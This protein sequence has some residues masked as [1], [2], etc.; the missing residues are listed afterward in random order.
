[1][2]GSS[3][4]IETTTSARASISA[5][6]FLGFRPTRSIP[7]SR[8]ASMTMGWTA[9]AGL[10]PPETAAYSG[11]ACS[12]RACAIWLRPAFRRQRKR[13]VMERLYPIAKPHRR[14]EDSA[15][16]RRGELACARVLLAWVIGG[17]EPAAL[18][19]RDARA[20]SEHRS[21]FDLGQPELPPRLHDRFK[22][23]LPQREPDVELRKRA[24]LPHEVLPAAVELGG[25]RLVPGRRAST[26]G[27]D[28]Y[29]VER[30]AVVGAQSIGP[31]REPLSKQLP[32]EPLAGAVSGEHPPRSVR[33][34]RPRREPHDEEP[35]FRIAKPGHRPPPVG[36]I[37][38]GGAAHSGHLG[39]ILA[40]SRA[41]FA[42]GHVARDSLERSGVAIRRHIWEYSR[43]VDRS[44]RVHGF[45]R[46][47]RGDLGGA[48]PPSRRGRRPESRRVDSRFPLLMEVAPQ[49]LRPRDRGRGLLDREEHREG[50]LEVSGRR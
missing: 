10:E 17:E 14:L 25:L 32:V 24:H 43:F 11:A 36:L 4:P 47:F 18:R 34:V 20:V 26:R 28:V 38:V 48:W 45:E 46:L 19:K 42:G 5:S 29:P 3:Q 23:D 22:G 21:R 12:K 33:S 7:T 27:R 49:P 50:Q 40:Q 37:A 13:T 44:R 39:A 8:I 9:A 2:A 1:M 16:H 15:P 6:T 35:R 31:T 41:S 30:E